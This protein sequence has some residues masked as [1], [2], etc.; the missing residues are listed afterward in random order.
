M[1]IDKEKLLL[2]IKKTLAGNQNLNNA[3][4]EGDKSAILQSL[5]EEDKNKINALLNDRES[6]NKL[7]NSQEAKEL[8]NKF[9]KDK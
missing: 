6:L 5:N 3:I 7:L 2:S 1:E 9:L 8:I 4:K